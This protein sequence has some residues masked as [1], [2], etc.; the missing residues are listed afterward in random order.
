MDKGDEVLVKM[1]DLLASWESANDR[2]VIFLS[3]YKMMTENILKAIQAKD[4][5][6]PPWV[7]ALMESFAGY[8]F[9]ALDKFENGLSN[10]PDVWKIAFQAAQNPRT[11]VLQNL[12]LGVNAHI[13]YDLVFALSELLAGEWE[14]L[15]SEQR[16]M[17]YRD[18]CRVNEV[19]THTIDEVQD[20]IID[21]YQPLFKVADKLMGPIDE[22]MTSLLIREW[23][24]EVWKHATRLLEPTEPEERDAIIQQVHHLSLVRAEDILGKGSLSQLTEFI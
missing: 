13:N 7:A 11:H 15:S 21:R 9:I 24:E 18:H 1:S 12:V 17:R 4:F 14:Q 5:E 3:C 6:D 16:M 2:R 22:W 19:I 20:Q 23:R 8:Y 10:S